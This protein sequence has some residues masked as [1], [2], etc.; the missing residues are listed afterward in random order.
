MKMNYSK[1]LF[2]ILF[3]LFINMSVPAEILLYHSDSSYRDWNWQALVIENE[4][5]SCAI[6]P[7]MGGNMMQYD[8]GTDTFLITN[9]ATYGHTY[10]PGQIQSPFNGSWGFGGFQ[11]WPTPEQWPPPPVLTYGQYKDTLLFY[12]DDSLQIKL[13]SP[14]EITGF[15]GIRFEKYYT[16]YNNSSIV[17]FQNA[18]INDGSAPLKIGTMNVAEIMT[19]HRDMGDYSN[20]RAYFPIRKNSVFGSQCVNITPV[21]PA[22]QGEVAPGVYGVE[23]TNIRGKVYADSPAGWM[24]FVDERDTQ[25][26]VCIYDVF[27]GKE[28][29]DQGANTEIYI[30]NALAF[31]ALEAITP[32]EQVNPV[33]D[34]FKFTESFAS[35]RLNG[36]I[37][38]VNI[39]GAVAERL[40][41]DTITHKITGRFGVFT[42]SSLQLVYCDSQENTLETGPEFHAT[43]DTTFILNLT[44]DLPAGTEL[45]KLRTYNLKGEFIADLD[46][47]D[48]QSDE[49]VSSI[50]GIKDQDVY[51]QNFLKTYLIERGILKIE[52]NNLKNIFATIELI[53]INGSM[54]QQLLSEEIGTDRQVIQLSTENLSKGVYLIRLYSKD[55]VCCKKLIIY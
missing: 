1:F 5:I 35:T 42:E 4:Y 20:F 45:I 14:T 55:L 54:L 46:L 27:D 13:T 11:I 51:N 9:P 50:V 7:S 6:V 23:Y 28:Y 44:V 17:K 24:A 41:Y 16:A 21:S 48:F 15:Q 32:L 2:L 33:T 36:I 25:T 8:F 22:F 38:K 53:D 47:E 34:T 37:Q 52:V 49:F 3:S 19:Q 30:E 18:I 12:T 29:P 10:I 26:Y 31:M 40:T 43:P 39:A